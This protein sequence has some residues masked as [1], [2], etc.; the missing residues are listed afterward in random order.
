MNYISVNDLK[1][2]DSSKCSG[3]LPHLVRKLIRASLDIK[4]IKKFKCHKTYKKVMW[5]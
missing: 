3:G 2:W 4:E 5:I 1:N